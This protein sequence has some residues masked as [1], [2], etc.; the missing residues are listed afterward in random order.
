MRDNEG[1][2]S[3]VPA[4]LPAP[5]PDR[6]PRR[7][8]NDYATV[9]AVFGIAGCVL[10]SVSFLGLLIGGLA[11]VFGVIG[12]VYA[13]KHDV[14]MAA[15]LSGIGFGFVAVALNVFSRGTN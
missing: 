2:S 15:T 9:A 1:V 8:T 6:R 4:D 7:R 13:T 12:L 10:Y 11:I 5:P 14:G 3:P